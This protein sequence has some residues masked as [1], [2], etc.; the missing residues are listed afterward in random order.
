MCALNS[1]CNIIPVFDNF[2]MPEQEILPADMRPIT[3]Y[4][5]VRWIHDY[6]A[7]VVPLRFIGLL[8]SMTKSKVT[9]GAGR[10]VLIYCW[11]EW[12]TF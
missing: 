1:N 12:R 2:V 7:S 5:G 4:N 9:L 10:T 11:S 8:L 6:Q 3:S